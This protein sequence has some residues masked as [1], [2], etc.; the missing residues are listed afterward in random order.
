MEA[1][2]HVLPPDGAAM[3]SMVRND[4]RLGAI[5]ADEGKLDDAG[6]ERVVELQRASGLRFGDAALCLHLVTSD[7]L[8][9]AVAKQYD[10]PCLP[11]GNE[12]ISRELVVASEPFGQRAEQL[13]AL[14]T[15]LLIRWS[16][17]GIRR[18]VLV[19]ASPGSG[20]GRS[21][22]VANLAVA[23]AQL[24]QRTLLIDADLR[25]PRLQRIFNIP[26]RP[27]LS[28]VLSGRADRSAL[29]SMPVFGPLCVMP[30][31]AT[32]PNPQ[33]LLLRP[34][35]A[36]LLD[37]MEAEFDVVLLDSSP[38]KDYADAQSLAFRAGGALVLVRKDHTRRDDTTGVI[39]ELSDTG[40]RIVGTVLNTF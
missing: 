39:R 26:E 34:A 4:R 31:G 40:A 21:Y 18:R 11:P 12:S 36:G 19:I 16:N 6:I 13:R 23:F 3:R 29:V 35:L 27:G 14:R 1:R 25:A 37:Q 7:D 2:D 33:E 17:S 38:A 8:R 15:Q 28:A 10:F 22:V 24:G 9:A 5:L 30:A 32:P 20:E